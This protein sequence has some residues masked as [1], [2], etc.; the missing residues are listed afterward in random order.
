MITLG[1]THG[2]R[3]RRALE[4]TVGVGVGVFVR[5][6]IVHWLGMGWWQVALRSGISMTI[7]AALDDG[8]AAHHPGRRAGSDRGAAVQS[9]PRPSAAGS[10]RSS[11]PPRQVWPFAAIEPTST[12]LRPRVRAIALL[13]DVSDVLTRTAAAKD[14]QGPSSRQ[15][16]LVDAGHRGR[17]VQRPE[18]RDRR[19]PRNPAPTLLSTRRKA[20]IATGPPCSSRSI[21][22]SATCASSTGARLCLQTGEDVPAPHVRAVAELRAATEMLSSTTSNA[23][24]HHRGCAELLEIATRR[25]GARATLGRGD[26]GPR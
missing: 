17:A 20:A 18:G 23:A 26:Q 10:R 3:L 8:A 19:L 22:R 24:P 7:A 16:V 5:E 14:P 1:M 12:V 9:H 11:A 6:I 21:G 25:A 4:I 15:K 13:R 2:Q